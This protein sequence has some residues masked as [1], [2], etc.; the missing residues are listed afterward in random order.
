MSSNGYIMLIP[1]YVGFGSCKDLVHPYYNRKVNNNAV[2]DM[3]QACREL[4]QQ[5]DILARSNERYYLMGYSQGGWATL[6]ALDEIEN[7]NQ[8]GFDI[9]ATSCGAGA[10]DLITMSAFLLEKETFPGPLYLPYFIYANQQY[11]SLTDPLNKY[12]KETYAAR[13]PVLF[14]GSY[15]NG[16]VNAQLTDTINDLVTDDLRMNFTTG[17]AFQALRTQMTENSV[18]AWSTNV[19]IHIYHGTSDINVPPFQSADLYNG[20]NQAG[21]DATVQYIEMNGLTHETGLIPWGIKTINWF[22]SLEGK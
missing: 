9:V 5:K 12:F 17:P 6:S 15:A 11:G 16:E 14:N 7:E 10:Y 3:M 19:L 13:I 2:I 4:L 21:A 22:N 1:D 18:P 20:F 8:T